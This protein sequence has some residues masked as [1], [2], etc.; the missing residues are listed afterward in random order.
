MKTTL[1]SA[2]IINGILYFKEDDGIER[3]QQFGAFY[4]EHPSNFDFSAGIKL[5]QNYYLEEDNDV[6]SLYK[7]FHRKDLQKSLLGYSCSETDQDELLQ[8]ECTLWDEYLPNPVAKLL[9][10]MNDLN[11]AVL[12]QLF[13]IAGIEEKYINKI[14][15]GL[16]SNQALQYC[17]FN[18]FRS[19]AP[20]PVGLTAHKDSGFTTLLYTTEPGLES[21][22]GDLWIPFNPLPGH[23]TVVLGH[24]LEILTEH[25]SKPFKSSYHRVQKILPRTGKAD[26]FTFGSYIGPRWDQKLYQ[27]KNGNLTATQSFIEFQRQKALEMGYPFH[28]N[29]DKTHP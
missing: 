7:G 27:F 20:H 23:F 13:L 29:V 10:A 1:P 11:R 4:L 5:A 16:S 14:T 24:S 21:L 8:L 26:R 9:W 6:D 22:E 19:D 17:I 15:G 18:H 12:I 2:R 28:P 25:S 3:T